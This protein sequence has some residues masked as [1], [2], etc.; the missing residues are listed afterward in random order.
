MKNYT[1]SKEMKVINMV[2]I[3]VIKHFVDY[4]VDQKDETHFDF[5]FERILMK[6]Y[7]INYMKRKED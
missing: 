5:Y 6:L 7:R 4:L 2:V 1:T 3:K